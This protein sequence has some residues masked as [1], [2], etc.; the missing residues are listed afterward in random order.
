MSAYP[1]APVVRPPFG[2]PVT[3]KQVLD[4]GAQV[5]DQR[6]AEACECG[7]LCPVEAA[8]PFAAVEQPAPQPPA[9]HGHAAEIAEVQPGERAGHRCPP[10]TRS[11]APVVKPEAGLAS[12]SAA[13]TSTSPIER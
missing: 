3:V 11:S 13:V 7:V 5:H 2:D 9:A 10:A 4:R 1:V 8:R 6:D 12:I